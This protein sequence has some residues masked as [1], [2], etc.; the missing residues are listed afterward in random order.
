MYFSSLIRSIKEINITTI[1]GG[2]TIMMKTKKTMATLLA[3]ALFVACCSTCFAAPNTGTRMKIYSMLD[4]SK[5]V[6]LAI[7]Q[8]ATPSAGDNV[9]LYSYYPGNWTKW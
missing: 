8:N 3:L 6:N 2:I 5:V 1:Y 7:N 9:T 4:T